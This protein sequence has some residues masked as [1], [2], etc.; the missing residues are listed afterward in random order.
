MGDRPSPSHWPTCPTDPTNLRA[1][2]SSTRSS[3]PST[4][5]HPAPTAGGD[6]AAGRG[7]PR[8]AAPLRRHLDGGVAAPP[9]GRR[10]QSGISGELAALRAEAGERLDEASLHPL[11][12]PN[13]LRERLKQGVELVGL[14]PSPK[15]RGGTRWS[16]GSRSA[17]GRGRNPRACRCTASPRPLGTRDRPASSSSVAASS[18]ATLKPTRWGVRCVG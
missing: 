1:S 2:G 17:R 16:P 5:G 12:L 15:L 7:G 4:G 9:E 8:E 14:T 3:A 18:P 11:E 6:G 10:G 13:G